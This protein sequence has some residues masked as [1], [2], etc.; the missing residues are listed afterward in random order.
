MPNERGEIPQSE[1]FAQFKQPQFK[2]NTIGLRKGNALVLSGIQPTMMINP[3]SL[4]KNA[5]IWQA[6]QIKS[7]LSTHLPA[8][9]SKEAYKQKFKKN[10]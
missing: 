9:Y 3:Q 7:R 10:R 5:Q 8:A 6:N 2:V 1:S 4:M